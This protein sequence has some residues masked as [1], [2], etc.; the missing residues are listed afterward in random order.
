MAKLS[1]DQNQGRYFKFLIDSGA[2]Y[3]LIP[4]SKAILLGLN[5]KKLKDTET[6]VESANHNYIRTKKTQLTITID[7][8][9]L[10]IPVLICEE[11]VECLLGRKG[12]F[13]NFNI[14][15]K[16]KDHEVIFDKT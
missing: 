14:I 10:E 7:K 11:E 16:E 1:K 12:V 8:I 9:K 6:R 13:E 15:F 3:T 2:D 4:K 5:Y